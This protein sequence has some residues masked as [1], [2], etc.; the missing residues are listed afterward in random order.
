M[1]NIRKTCVFKT[2]VKRIF[3]ASLT[4]VLRKTGVLLTIR[5]PERAFNVCFEKNYFKVLRPSGP[6]YW[7][8]VEW[9]PY[10]FYKE[11]CSEC[12]TN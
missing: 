6:N 7:E 12:Q 3:N 10:L 2:H 5:L 4:H 1:C 9:I 8:N 11:Y